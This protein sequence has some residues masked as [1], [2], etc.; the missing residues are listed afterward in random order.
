DRV[1]ATRF[2]L[3]AIDAVAAKDFGKMVALQSTNIVR[4]PFI[5]ATGE[6]KTVPLERYEEARPFF[7]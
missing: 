1:L 6:L 5:D 4:V 7:G 2:G 3:S